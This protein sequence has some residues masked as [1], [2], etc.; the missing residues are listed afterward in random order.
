[1]RASRPPPPRG[2][3]LPASPEAY[4]S[5]RGGEPGISGGD[6]D[7]T[8]YLLHAMQALY[9]LSYAPVGRGDGT[10]GYVTDPVCRASVASVA[11][12]DAPPKFRYNATLANEIE[13]RWQD[14]W[15]AERVFWT[16]N[17]T[18]LLAED[19]RGLADRPPLFVLDM[20]PYPSGKGL[21]VGHPLGFIATDVYGALPAHE[22]L[23]RAARDGLR[24]VRAAR[25]SSTRCRPG[26]H[27]RVT[28]EQN[29]ATMKA[30]LRALGLAHDPRRG[31]GHHRRV[32]LPLDAVDLP[33]DLQLLV[34]RGR[35]SG[36]ADRRAGRGVPQRRAP[37]ARRHPVRRP[38]P[39]R[40]AAS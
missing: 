3:V 15:E 24:R 19:P 1:M 9:Q 11:M 33:A 5:S 27:P 28:T 37:D 29:I 26:Q 8:H 40:P 16:P 35:G 2:P 6:G 25:P 17:R 14:R 30:Q 10:R 13:R 36:A 39:A 34:R 31:P 20:F 7:R 21:H 4:E 38:G 23:Q 22:R 18:G 32:V 12:A